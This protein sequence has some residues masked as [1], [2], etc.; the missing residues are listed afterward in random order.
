[1]RS[2]SKHRIKLSRYR[3][4][5]TTHSSGIGTRFCVKWLVTASSSVEAHAASAIHN[6]ILPAR[7]TDGSSAAAARIGSLSS[8]FFNRAAT[9]LQPEIPHAIAN[10]AYATDHALAC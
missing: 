10:T 5:G 2:L 8:R 7:G 9:L 1:M 3:L 6:T 4:R